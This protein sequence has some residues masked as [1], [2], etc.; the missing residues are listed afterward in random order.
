MA[1]GLFALAVFVSMGEVSGIHA[2]Q[3]GIY[4]PGNVITSRIS[5]E[6][7]F[8][9]YSN[10]YGSLYITMWFCLLRAY[11][12]FQ[13]ASVSFLSKRRA[14]YIEQIESLGGSVDNSA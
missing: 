4:G 14:K 3:H 7:K 2:H 13:V 1:F 9:L 8:A 10:I 11:A 6:S 12:W 5:I